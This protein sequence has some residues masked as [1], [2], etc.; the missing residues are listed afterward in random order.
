MNTLSIG[1]IVRQNVHDFKSTTVS[2]PMQFFL[3][4][5]SF[6]FSVVDMVSQKSKVGE[7][8]RLVVS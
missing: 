3:F 4:G 7:R 2:I 1:E 5:H 8:E 6:L